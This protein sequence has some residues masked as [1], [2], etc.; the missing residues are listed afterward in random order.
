MQ[1]RKPVGADPFFYAGQ[2]CDAA[3]DPVNDEDAAVKH[4]YTHHHVS[5]PPIARHIVSETVNPQVVGLV[6]GCLQRLAAF[7]IDRS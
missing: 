4:A 3:M 2:V 5:V 1:R 6:L 7:P